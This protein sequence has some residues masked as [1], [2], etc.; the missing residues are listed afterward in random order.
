MT[1]SRDEP[2]DLILAGVSSGLTPGSQKLMSDIWRDWTWAEYCR[3]PLENL[4]LLDEHRLT[5]GD[6]CGYSLSCLTYTAT[7]LVPYGGLRSIN[8]QAGE[9]I[10]ISPATGPFGAAAVHV[11]LAMGA[12]VIAMGR[13]KSV[14]HYLQQMSSDPNRVDTVPITNDMMADLRALKQEG[15]NDIDAFFDIGPPEA[16]K[17]THLLSAIM[18]LK[19]G[20]RVSLMGGYMDDMPLP[21]RVIMRKN[22]TLKGNWMYQPSDRQALFKM[23]ESGVLDLKSC[24]VE[25]VY[26]LDDLWAAVDA[27][28]EKG[29][30]GRVVVLEP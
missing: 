16:S 23:V 21:H 11:A 18:A 25:G 9:T 28:A 4:T 7:L 29:G 12:N 14:L 5:S 24:S 1:R 17:S 3:A 27:A 6:F 8:L 15:G 22:L 26:G 20:G 13:D 30:P 19:V 10:I 2:G